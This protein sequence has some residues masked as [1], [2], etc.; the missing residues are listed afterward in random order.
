MGKGP[1]IKGVLSGLTPAEKIYLALHPHQIA[2]IRADADKALA[3]AQRLFPGATLHNGEGD[4]FRHCYWSAL[5]GRDIG[6]NNAVQFTSAHEGFSDNPSGERA[7]DLHN[8][9]VGA[10]IGGANSGSPDGAI[11]LLCQN[12]LSTGKLK[13]APPTPGR[14]Y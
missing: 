2:V 9:A 12:A 14:P 10:G 13:T 4:A 3:E 5:L 8:N 6:K 7:M 1:V 11:S